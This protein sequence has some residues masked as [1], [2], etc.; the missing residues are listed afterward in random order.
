MQAQT[1][2]NPT[3]TPR[4]LLKLHITQ[5]FCMPC[6]W[7]V[8]F[9]RTC[10]YLKLYTYWNFI[11]IPFCVCSVR[12]QNFVCVIHYYLTSFQ[13][14]V[15]LGEGDGTP[16]QYSC[17]ENPMDRG[18]WWA[19]VHQVTKSRTRLS[20]FPFTFHFQA[21]EKCSCLEN[22][23]DGGSWW[24]AVYGVT[25]SQTRLKRLSSSSSSKVF[26]T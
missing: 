24:A 5:Y 12:R 16:F 9:F 10:Y 26:V 2:Y 18:A 17:L 4:I 15:W 8:S 25:Q 23:R 21:L 6:P 3:W 22:P 14:K 13:N 20:D 1:I 19:A 7:F 11:V